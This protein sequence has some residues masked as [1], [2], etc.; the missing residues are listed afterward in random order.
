MSSTSIRTTATAAKKLL[1]E[2]REQVRRRHE[3]G[4]SGTEIG[5]LLTDLVDTLVLKLLHEALR[6]VKGAGESRTSRE[7][8]G[9]FS[10]IA[11]G[12]YGRRDLAPFSDIDLMVLIQPD[13]DASVNPLITRLSQ[14]LYDA[15]FQLGL[16][17]R[18]FREATDLALGDATIFTA[19]AEAR[20]LAGNIEVYQAF[21]DRLVKLIKRR[22]FSLLESS[23]AARREERGNYGE[24][25][26]LLCP[27]VKRSRGGLRDLQLIRWIAFARFGE[28]DFDR[29]QQQNL[30]SNNDLEQILS[31]RDFLHRVRNELHFH[32]GKSQD[33]LSREEQV[34]IAQK[35]GYEGDAG[36]LPVEQ[37]MRNYFAHSSQVKYIAANFTQTARSRFSLSDLVGPV[38]SF[39]VS[40]DF[41]IGPVHVTATRKGLAKLENSLVDVLRLMDLANAYN[42]RIDHPT[43]MAIRDNMLECDDLKLDEAVASRFVAFMSETNRLGPLLRR[44]HELRVLEKIITPMKRARCLLQFN[45]YHKYTVDEHCI[46]AVEIG[47]GWLTDPGEVGD[48]YR[49]LK[50]PKLLHLALLLHD[51]GKG[52]ER[53]HSEL[54]AELADA[55]CR[56]LH[57]TEDEVEQVSFLVLHHLRMSH[58]AFY[59]DMNDDALIAEFAATVQSIEMLKMLLVLTCSDLAAVGPGVLNNWKQGLLLELYHRTRNQLAGQSELDP[60]QQETAEIRRQVE[61]KLTEAEDHD[62]RVRLLRS[63][64]NAIVSQRTVDEVLQQVHKLSQIEEGNSTISTRLLQDGTAVEFIVGTV[65]RPHSGIFHRITGTLTSARMEILSV[66][67]SGLDLRKMVNRFL[68]RDLEPVGDLQGSRIEKICNDLRRTLEDPAEPIPPFRKV[69]EPSQAN[70][71]TTQHRLPTRVR[72]DN[73]TSDSFTIIDVFAHDALGLLYAISRAIF[74]LRLDVHYAKVGTFLDQVV[75]VFYVTDASGGKLHDQEAIQKIILDVTTT[76]EEVG[77]S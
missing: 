16:S 64:P 4:G 25:V 38:F 63:L 27:N 73:D 62:S 42:R 56:Q 54:G 60:L 67:A 22:G 74:E 37:F 43:W 72:I 30:L 29:I 33:L 11:V 32:A 76:V 58:L 61:Q 18:D 5:H 69:W 28:T 41:R 53:D 51:L 13:A 52:D 65:D 12:G 26:F 10:L 70:L 21:R 48:I 9:Q 50:A 3:E 34:R 75:D 68:V 40:R 57:L 7:L 23:L 71:K 46:R 77:R 66:D 35:F 1:M 39:R 45:E 36:V 19:M 49:S 24:T 8:Q 59:R 6:E 20:Y 14:D 31:A 44:M 15:G 2:G 17:V 55:T 47:A